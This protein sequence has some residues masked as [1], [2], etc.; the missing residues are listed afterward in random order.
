VR[1]S[2]LLQGRAEF[3]FL[4]A[5]SRGLYGRLLRSGV[6]IFELQARLLHSK[7]AL[8][9]DSLVTVGSYN[10]DPLSW[11]VNLEANLWVKDVELASQMGESFSRVMSECCI[12]IDEN[13]LAEES[14][15]QRLFSWAAYRLSLFGLALLMPQFFQRELSS[16]PFSVL[17]DG[18]DSAD[19]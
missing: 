4:K 7:A 9:D 2:L 16:E 15:W 6:Q 19:N 3:A 10:L 17:K 11:K 13:H 18:G 14:F 5:A 12:R 8:F 1:V